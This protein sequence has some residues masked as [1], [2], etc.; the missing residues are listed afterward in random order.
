MEWVS[1][2]L[3]VRRRRNEIFAPRDPNKPVLNWPAQLPRL[4]E[5]SMKMEIS[6]G[7]LKT[8]LPQVHFGVR[9]SKL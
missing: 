6:P 2:K 3:L 5:I 4:A 9:E 7:L 8:G 1:F